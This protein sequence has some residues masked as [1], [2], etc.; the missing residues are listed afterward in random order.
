MF[1]KIL[2]KY[3]FYGESVIKQCLLTGT[4]HID[5]SGEP[6]FL[7]KMQLYYHNEALDKQVF[8]IGSCGYD[9]VPAD[10]GVLFTQQS[11]QSINVI[12]IYAV[13]FNLK[14]LIYR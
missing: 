7:E 1:N 13:L 6:E 10:I 12:N 5:V 2:L 4:H 11:F 9:S 3:R 14:I 8:V